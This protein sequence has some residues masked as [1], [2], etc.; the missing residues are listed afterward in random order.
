M[1]FLRLEKNISERL[2][3]DY[4]NQPCSYRPQQFEFVEQELPHACKDTLD[5]EMKVFMK[6][7]REGNN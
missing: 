4:S 1:N 3:E 2:E 5:I 7:S 6:Y